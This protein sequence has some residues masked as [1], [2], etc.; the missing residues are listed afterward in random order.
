MA[1]LICDRHLG[2]LLLSFNIKSKNPS[3]A[4]NISI[5]YPLKTPRNLNFYSSWNHQKTT[6]FLMISGGIEVKVFCCF[7]RV[8]DGNIGHKWFYL[9]SAN[10]TNWSNTLKQF[11]YNLSTNCL[12]VFDH[13]KNWHYLLRL[14]W[15]LFTLFFIVP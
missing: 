5:L 3:F 1:L 6:G 10:P 13:F 14:P 11:V 8:W 4:A 9:L 15:W 2:F 12:S 7:Q